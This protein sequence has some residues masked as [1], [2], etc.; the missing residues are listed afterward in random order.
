MPVL[1]HEVHHKVK[2][3]SDA[4]YGC[5]NTK[6][7]RAGYYVKDGLFLDT[8]QV[9]AIQKVKYIED[10]GSLECRYDQSLVD[11]KCKGCSHQGFG[12][13]YANMIK[14]LGK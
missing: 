14:E 5:W 1:A 11:N 10:F 8:S 9:V 3:P 6:R 2:E 7:S 12:E 4:K 13:S